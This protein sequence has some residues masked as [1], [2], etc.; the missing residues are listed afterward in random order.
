MKRNYLAIALVL[1]LTPLLTGNAYVM[2]VAGMA[3]WLFALALALDVVAGLAGLLDLGFTAFIAVGAYAYAFL[4]SGHFGLHLAFPIT[5]A[6]GTGAGALTGLLVG[7]PSLRLRDDYLAI[8]T[9]AL[10]QIARIL[11]VNLD[12]PVNITNGPNGIIRLDPASIGGLAATSPAALYCLMLGGAIVALI[13]VQAVDGFR[14][15]RALRAIRDRQVVAEALGFPAQ[16]LKVAAFVIGAS[17][18]AGAGVLFAAWQ[19]SVFPENFDMSL[20]IAVYCVFVLGGSRQ[21][22]AM[23]LAAVGLVLVPEVL[24]DRRCIGWCSTASC[25]RPGSYGGGFGPQKRTARE[26]P[27]DERKVRAASLL[28][29]AILA[30]RR[31][32]VD[33]AGGGR[34]NRVRVA[35]DYA[36]RI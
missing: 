13:A 10:G 21:P 6:A 9:L 8:V 32:P 35:K 19:G 1:G 26:A 25:L 23:L 27:G 18:M 2:R 12:R 29:R 3:L 28:H 24:R 16:G 33:G 15:G 11:L 22:A 17:L 31:S 5:L 4:A 34:S 30:I 20:L 36:S 7:V 14:L